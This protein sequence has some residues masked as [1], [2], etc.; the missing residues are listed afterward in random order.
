MDD[1]GSVNCYCVNEARPTP[2]AVALTVVVA[3]GP[4]A[5]GDKRLELD[6]RGEFSDGH[7]DD[8]STFSPLTAVLSQSL[9]VR[10][11]RRAK[12]GSSSP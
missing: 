12:R 3:P 10:M 4:M 7:G 11:M 8:G 2:V 9:A 5:R 1:C 6:D